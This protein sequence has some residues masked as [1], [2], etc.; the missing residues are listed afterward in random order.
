MAEKFGIY[1]CMM[2][3]NTIE[4]IEAHPPNVV[5][6]GHEMNLMQENTQEEGGEKHLPVVEKEEGFIEVKVGSTPHPMDDSHYIELVELIRDGKVI[7][8]KWLYPGDEPRANFSVESTE[9]INA[10]IYC[11]VHGAWKK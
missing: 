8:G 3:G 11:N 6:C 4:M 7:A 1:K 10:R 5:C 2:C 9:G